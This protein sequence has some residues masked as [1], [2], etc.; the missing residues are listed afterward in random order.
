MTTVEGIDV[1]EFGLRNAPLGTVVAYLVGKA[2]L[3]HAAPQALVLSANATSL[4]GEVEQ[5]ALVF[6]RQAAIAGLR[7]LLALERGQ[8]QRATDAFR[9]SRPGLEGSSTP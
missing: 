5:L 3:D 8:V 9:T 6:R 2:V 1:P 4:R 7:G